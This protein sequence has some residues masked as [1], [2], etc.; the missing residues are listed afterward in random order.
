MS[1]RAQIWICFT[2]A[3]FYVGVKRR[4]TEFVQSNVWL[5][6]NSNRPLG[7]NCAAYWKQLPNPAV[8]R[9]IRLPLAA[10][11]DF[12]ATEIRSVYSLIDGLWDQTVCIRTKLKLW[13][14]TGNQKHPIK[15]YHVFYSQS[16]RTPITKVERQSEV[17]AV[18]GC[19][20]IYIFVWVGTQLNRIG[21]SPIVVF[22]WEW[23]ACP[24]IHIFDYRLH[25]FLVQPQVLRFIYFYLSCPHNKFHQFI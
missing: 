21:T 25:A 17:S 7:Y 23:N 10:I 3:K 6:A 13:N 12:G 14:W 22:W 24:G 2:R 16:R 9:I 11:L 4:K 20:P 15:L 19:R 18:A 1:D 5:F 8:W